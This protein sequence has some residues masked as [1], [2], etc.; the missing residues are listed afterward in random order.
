MGVDV[1][2]LAH[3]YPHIYNISSVTG[4]RELLQM[5]VIAMDGFDGH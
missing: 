2:A 4:Q 5:F 1:V 3:T